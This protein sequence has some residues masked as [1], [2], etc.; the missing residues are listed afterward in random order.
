MGRADVVVLRGSKWTVDDLLW[1]REMGLDI[2]VQQYARAGL[3]VGICGGMQMLGETIA[4]PL[5]ME[6]DGS[7][8]GLGLLPIR[9]IMQ[10]NK[11]TR[12][13]TGGIV[14]RTLFC[15]A[16]GGDRGCGYEMRIWRC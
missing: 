6:R 2:A 13:V 9:T 7:V 14:A 15:H 8:A 5:G 12:N 11:V 1:M 4:D 10:A 16:V 3:V